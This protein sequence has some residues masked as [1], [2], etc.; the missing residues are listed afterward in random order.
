VL[1]LLPVT[2]A[3]EVLESFQAAKALHALNWTQKSVSFRQELAL[4]VGSLQQEPSS[5]KA[6]HFATPLGVE[7]ESPE[8][9]RYT[10]EFDPPPEGDPPP[11]VELSGSSPTSKAQ[12][13]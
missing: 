6:V 2:L 5:H 10:E 9:A 8:H 7:C 11:E 4:S 3:A 1:I 13:W 12:S